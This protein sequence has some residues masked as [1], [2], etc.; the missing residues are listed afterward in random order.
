METDREAYWRRK[1]RRLRIGAEPIEA[2]L[3]RQFRATVVLTAIP[4]VIGSMILAIFS[5]FGRP[6]VG[7]A[8]AGVLLLP[9]VVLAWLD[10]GVLRA[11]ASSY[12]RETT[13][14]ENTD[15]PPG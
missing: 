3:D 1:L 14:R 4:G 12:L 13:T 11:R 8:V 5:A 2:Q 10:Y 6:D 9:V 15:A 7:L